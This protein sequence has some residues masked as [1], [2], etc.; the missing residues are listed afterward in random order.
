MG[1]A[2][3]NYARLWKQVAPLYGQKGQ[4]APT[5]AP[6]PKGSGDAYVTYNPDLTAQRAVNVSPQERLQLK[7]NPGKAQFTFLHEWGH[8]FGAGNEGDANRV[9]NLATRELRGRMPAKT[10]RQKIAKTL[11]INDGPFPSS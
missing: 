6:V 3:S 7:R 9:A 1:V 8:V 4:S 5:F 11:A 2:R 10:A